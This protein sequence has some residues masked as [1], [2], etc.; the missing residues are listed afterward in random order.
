MGDQK[1]LD[2]IVILNSGIKAQDFYERVLCLRNNPQ[3]R[4][5]Y[6]IPPIHHD[7]NI[8][9]DNKL[10]DILNNSVFTYSDNPLRQIDYR[11]FIKTFHWSGQIEYTRKEF[12]ELG[13]KVY[14]NPINR[15]CGDPNTENHALV[16]DDW[17][18]LGQTMESTLKEIKGL[19]YKNPHYYIKEFGAQHTDGGI[20]TE[21][22]ERIPSLEEF[23]ELLRT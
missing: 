1:P 13:D 20:F 14:E 7:F 12:K 17:W 4:L 22:G 9:T 5:T 23:L 8:Y 19:G 21:S 3:D 15:F 18:H 11:K 6:F 2:I 16:V 10:S